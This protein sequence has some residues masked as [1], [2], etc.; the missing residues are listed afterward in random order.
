[1]AIEI[2]KRTK[3]IAGVGV[4]VAVAAAAGV[5]FFLF[6]EEAPPP[7]VPV[8]AKPAAKPAADAAKS[9][10]DAPKPAADALKAAATPAKPAAAK[11]LPTNPDQA[12]AE[13]LDASGARTQ[14]QQLV[15]DIVSGGQIKDPAAAKEFA[16]I[17]ERAFEPNALIAE[18]TLNLK[19]VYDA[20]RLS[21]YLE[22]LRQPVSL[23]MIAMRTQ[24]LAPSAEEMNAQMEKIKQN[25]LAEERAKLI[26]RLEELSR[27]AGLG[28]EVGQT[29]ARGYAEGVLEYLQASK[30][31]KAA[32]TE[33]GEGDARNARAVLLARGSADRAGRIKRSVANLA[34]V[35]RDASDAEL[36]EYLKL[37]DTEIG[38]WGATTLAAAL[39]PA[40]EKRGRAQ[41]RAFA[42]FAIE[43][44]SATAKAPAAATPVAEASAAK[45]AAAAPAEKTA[46][47]AP[48]A[49]AEPPGYKRAANV[50]DLYTRYND[51]VTATVMRDRVAVKELLDDGKYPNVRQMDGATPLMI[52]AANGDTVIAEMLLAKGADANLR[53]PDGRSALAHAKARGS[54]ELVRL[55]ERHGAK[56]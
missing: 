30:N 32:L 55:L 9:A 48:A 35:Y 22:L 16:A 45:P 36:A 46:A 10:P 44:R 2:S 18:V 19:T 31:G 42:Q 15:R 34:V 4:L 41:G 43:G 6:E 26:A 13:F 28:S 5:W 54:A 23:K 1:M 20:N 52:A 29:I 11:P 56:N 17:L 27:N 3:V 37:I 33:I 39:A 21:R 7:P 40:M 50:R 38:E 49:P 8:A 51:L 14:L 25:P 24:A 47:A 53:T 12:I